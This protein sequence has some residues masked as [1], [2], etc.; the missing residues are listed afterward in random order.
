MAV[1]FFHESNGEGEKTD[2]VTPLT[3]RRRGVTVHGASVRLI[4]GTRLGRRGSRGAHGEATAPGRWRFECAGLGAASTRRL[5]GTS[6]RRGRAQ[7]PWA[8]RLS[9]VQAGLCSAALGAV[10]RDTRGKES[11][12][13]GSN[14][15]RRLGLG[16]GRGARDWALGR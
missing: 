12:G 9:G 3:H 15:E 16:L 5:H 1:G 14:K 10:E 8:S 13:G 7:G 2:A 6:G 4:A 11:Q